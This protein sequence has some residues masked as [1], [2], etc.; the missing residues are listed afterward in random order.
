M[1][2]G[3]IRIVAAL[4]VVAIVLQRF[5]RKDEPVKNAPPMVH[6]AVS[7]SETLSD[8]GVVTE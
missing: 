2:L 1:S 3:S 5:L 4:L 7:F 6:V 8:M